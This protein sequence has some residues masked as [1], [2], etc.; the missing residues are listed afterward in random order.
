M[1]L[2]VYSPPYLFKGPRPVITAAPKEWH[3]DQAVDI[4]SPQ[5]GRMRWASLMRNALLPD[6]HVVA[7]GGNPRAGYPRGMGKDPDKLHP[8]SQLISISLI[9]QGLPGW[10]GGPKTTIRARLITRWGS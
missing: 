7:A 8:C 10:Q 3:Y 2:D 4:S 9:E 5:A 1:R 6:G